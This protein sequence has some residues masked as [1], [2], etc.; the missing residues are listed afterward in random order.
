MIVEIVGN[1]YNNHSLSIVNRNLALHLNAEVF[2]T[3]LDKP[4][5]D[6]GLSKDVLK[7]LRELEKLK[8]L[9]VPDVQIRH[10][11]P[12]IW[13][14][15]Q[16]AKTKVVFI[17]P[18][19]YS[20]VPLEWV[21]RFQTFADALISFSNF[22]SNIYA[23]AGI[24]PSKIY[25]IPIGSNKNIF[26][27]ENRD[28]SVKTKKRYMYVGAAGNS[29]QRKGVDLLINGWVNAFKSYNDVELII[30]DNTDVYGK[31]SFLLDSLKAQYTHD[32]A[33]ITYIEDRLSETEMADLYRS[34]DFILHPYRGE[35]YGLPVQEAVLCG[36]IPLVTA[37]GSTDDFIP[38]NLY[39][40]NNWVSKIETNYIPNRELVLEP[41]IHDFITKLKASYLVPQTQEKFSIESKKLT[42]MLNLEQMAELYRT[43]LEEVSTLPTI[44]PTRFS[45]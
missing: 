7:N 22:T 31:S 2:I 19:E 17:Q 45:V 32:A 21:F 12:P 30:K 20:N 41:N 43:V 42:N 14:Y 23:N 35:G 25:T 3:A 16:N 36:C 29:T 6:F 28:W 1:F 11:Y 24:D 33:E 38:D 27:T 44:R 34:C 40:S 9:G 39:A 18:W 26:N 37:G 4:N 15:P 10:T 13:R 8:T 5:T